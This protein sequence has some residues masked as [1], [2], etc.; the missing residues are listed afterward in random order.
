M[1]EQLITQI[2]ENGTIFETFY[3]NIA[4]DATRS[5]HRGLWR[6]RALVA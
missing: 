1:P 4:R 2:T 6:A 3:K 5:R